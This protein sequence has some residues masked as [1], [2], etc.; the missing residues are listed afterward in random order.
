MTAIEHPKVSEGVRALP[1]WSRPRTSLVVFLCLLVLIS[2]MLVA[3]F[4]QAVDRWTWAAWAVLPLIAMNA[5]WISGGAATA[6]VGLMTPKARA[7]PA[8]A[9]WTP[10]QKT[11]ILITLCGEDPRPVADYLSS[12]SHAFKRV[13]LTQATTIF[14]LSDTS[15]GP[16]SRA[17]EAAFDQLR[18]SG[19]VL[20]RR[21]TQRTGK[22]PGNICDWLDAWGA[23]FDHMIVLDADSRMSAD[24]ISHLIWKMETTPG[25]GLYQAGISL[26]PGRTRFGRYQRLTSRLLS[27]S[28]CRGFAA[29]AGTASNFWGHNAII[30]V[31]AFRAAAPL[32]HLSGTA[33]F[34]G[35]ILSHDFIEAAWIRRAG[36]D[37]ALCPDLP[38]SAE[39]APQTLAEYFRRDRRW[40]QGNLQHIRL[41]AEPGLHPL[42]RFHLIC[43]IFSYLAAPIW[44]ALL[45][46]LSFGQI[47]IWGFKSVLAIA[48]VLLIPKLCA[49]VDVLP[50]ARTAARAWVILRAW[51]AEVAL[52][53]LLAPIMMMRQATFVFSILMRQD[54]GWKGPERRNWVTLPLGW[55]EAGIGAGLSVFAVLSGTT[56]GVWLALVIFPLLSAPMLM[57]RLNEV[58]P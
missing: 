8:P 2:L 27:G 10:R 4:V 11:A 19:K 30:R 47:E 48:I 12:L 22:K 34:G 38:G 21:R 31:A 5:L 3:A 32:P 18:Q 23:D 36:W 35:A 39:D 14:A 56:G 24:A 29:W 44:L 51:W 40:C 55:T 54:C 17:E 20:Y 53:T 42:S 52:S 25:L 13:G 33:P 46:L 43:G 16:E 7:A 15:I 57:P 1:A 50:R 26:L 28:F 9:G 58:S 49:L 37:V 41:L 45:A 6:L